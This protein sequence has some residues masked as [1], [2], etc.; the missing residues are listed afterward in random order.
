[1]P[2]LPRQPATLA[3]SAATRVNRA[4]ALV[5]R[6]LLVC[7]LAALG[8]L[9]FMPTHDNQANRI[10]AF[11]AKAVASTGVPYD[12]AFHTLEFLANIALFVPFGALVPLALGALGGWQVWLTAFGGFVSSGAI[13]FA[14][15]F[16]P[17][18]V[19]DLRDIIANT[20]GTFLG[21]LLVLALQRLLL[22]RAPRR[23]AV[24][25]S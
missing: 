11:F 7:F 2:F 5:S 4:T 22:S 16:I 3:I 21:L 8:F 9:V 12:L 6:G 24:S 23:P 10:V 14:Q 1:M 13:E 25:F 19:S 15:R 20:L 18:R 17:G